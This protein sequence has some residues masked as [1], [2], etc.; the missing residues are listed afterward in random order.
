VRGSRS[1]DY[2]RLNAEPPGL[3]IQPCPLA[4]PG[5]VS[6]ER[7]SELQAE[8]RT[9]VKEDQA[10]RRPPIDQA[11]LTATDGANR[12]CHTSWLTRP[13]LMLALSV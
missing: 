5:P 3:V 4:N 1:S 11:K 13:A 9:R 7:R 8:L 6:P 2:E 12:V 10:V